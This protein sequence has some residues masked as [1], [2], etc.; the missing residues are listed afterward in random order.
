MPNRGCYHF[1]RK[2]SAAHDGK[3]TISPGA[4]ES[5]ASFDLR[6]RNDRYVAVLLN[7]NNDEDDDDDGDDKNL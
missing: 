5:S 4:S 1:V 7:I 3:L 2:K 6:S